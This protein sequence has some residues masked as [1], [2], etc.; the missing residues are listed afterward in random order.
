MKTKLLF[1]GL[2]TV[3]IFNYTYAQVGIGTTSPDDSSILDITSTEKGV[4]IPRMTALER[5]SIA[6]PIA[7][8]LM[9]YQTDDIKGFYYYDSSV[10]S[11][12]R[13]LKQS[14]DAVPTGAIFTFP[15]ATPPTGYLICDGSAISRTTYSDLFAII[16]V[17]YGN[18][19]GSTT[20]NLPDYRG[21]FLRGLNDGSG[22]DPDAATRQ[23]RGDGTAGDNVGTLQNG[24]MAS[25]Q[26]QIDPPSSTSNSS[27]IHTHTTISNN[28]TTN[29]TG[30]HSH[31]TNPRI[32]NTNASGNH[33]H[34]IRGERESI[35]Q[36]F[37][38]HGDF[39]LDDNGT[40][41]PHTIN[42]SSAGN[43]NHSVNIPSLSTN[44]TGN[45]NHT[46]NIPS[47]TTN[48]SGNHIHNTNIPAFDSAATGSTENRPTNISVIYCIKI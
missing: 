37:G 24:E 11:W 9:V 44:T 41:G 27:G 6:T 38:F 28:T 36:S 33:N 23:D 39:I 25:H 1:F 15:V 47:L 35:S 22:N 3:I 48:S 29:F 16:G 42:T 2:L 30:N 8:G 4:L 14:K 45:H 5:L 43:H 31:S 46:I 21:K 32:I 19:D 17:I 40:S 12:D 20:F 7:D 18:G 13:V 26:H 10:S 34:T